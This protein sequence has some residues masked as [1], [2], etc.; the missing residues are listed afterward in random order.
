[1]ALFGLYMLQK[2]ILDSLEKNINF[3]DFDAWYIL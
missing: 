2:Y 1:M 3:S